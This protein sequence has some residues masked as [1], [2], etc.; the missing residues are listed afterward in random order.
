MTWKLEKTRESTEIFKGTKITMW[1]EGEKIKQLMIHQ[2]K[3][4]ILIGNE[5]SEIFEAPH[6][7]HRQFKFNHK[8]RFFPATSLNRHFLHSFKIMKLTLLSITLILND[9]VSFSLA[10]N[11]AP[12]KFR[13]NVTATIVDFH[14]NIQDF[15]NAMANRRSR[16]NPKQAWNIRPTRFYAMGD[17]PY[18]LYERENLPNQLKLLDPTVDFSIHLG[19]MQFRYVLS[20]DI[21][22]CIDHA[23]NS[24]L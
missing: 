20:M 23:Y 16:S 11:K 9:M 13:S 2:P 19:D 1:T 12:T 14:T 22:C 8:K 24:S 3:F 6:L 4:E 21:D 5:I 15:E 7:Q 17:V 18:S 10:K